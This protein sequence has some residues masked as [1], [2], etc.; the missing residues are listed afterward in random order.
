MAFSYRNR[1]KAWYDTAQICLNGHII[2]TC[3]ETSPEHNKSFCD[4][5]GAETTINCLK[6]GG[7]IL[8]QLHPVGELTFVPPMRRAPNF[9]S[10]CGSLYPWTE[11]RLKAARDLANEISG[12]SEDERKLLTQSLDELVKDT[13]DTQT[14]AI[15]FKKI[16][17][18]AGKEAANA[19][20]QILI[21]FASEAAKKVIWGQ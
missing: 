13:P 20:R 3:A 4:K 17:S 18:K 11:R 16:V 1:E 14:A 12:I 7:K 15:R 5:C 2:N 10:S 9:C 6:C 21:D 19:F 8:G